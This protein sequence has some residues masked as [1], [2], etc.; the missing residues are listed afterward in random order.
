MVTVTNKY[1]L[2][3]IDLQFDQLIGAQ[4]FLKIGF[5]SGYHQIKICEEDILKIAFST[6][7]SLYEYLVMT[8]GLTNTPAHFMYL[9]NSVF[10]KEL[11]KFVVVF[12]DGILVFSKS[13]KE[14]EEHLYIV[15]Q[16]LRDDYL[17]AKFNKCE[18]WLSEVPFLG[19]VIS[20]EGI[21]MDPDKVWE[22]L[23]WK[24]PRTMHQVCSFLGLAGYYRRFILNFSKIAKPITD[25]LKKDEKFV[26]NTK[27]DEAFQTLKKLLTTSPMLAQ[28]DITKPF[29]VYCDASGTGLSCVLMQEGHVIAYSSCQLRPHEEHYLTHDLELATMVHALCTWRHYLLE[30]VAH[31]FTDHKSLKYFFSLR[32]IWTWVRED[33]WSWSRTMI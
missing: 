32:L 17:Y 16:W 29:N 12:I 18:F 3:H 7:Y 4:V 9:M 31:I 15:L 23:D 25:L 6:Q 11:D 2:P 28:P 10:M 13:K 26:W 20:S 8:F 19:H 14:Y 27:C 21:S 24:P 30:N 33:G 1:S 5:R 22:V